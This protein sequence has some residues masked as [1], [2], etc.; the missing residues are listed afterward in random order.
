[1][2]LTATPA[3]AGHYHPETGALECDLNRDVPDPIF[4][5]A[6]GVLA[7][8]ATIA[9]ALLPALVAADRDPVEV[10]RVP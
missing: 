9:A 2:I 3:L 1:M 8:I 4:T 6:V 7:V 10:L 5:I